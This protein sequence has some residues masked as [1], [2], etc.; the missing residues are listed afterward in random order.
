MIA[1]V[2]LVALALATVW[3][4]GLSTAQIGV[5]VAAFALQLVLLRFN[6]LCD[7]ATT[8]EV[9]SPA[10]PRLAIRRATTGAA[11]LA[12]VP[13]AAVIAPA[14]AAC[15]IVAV[16]LAYLRPLTALIRL[17]LGS[18]RLAA[19]AARH[20]AR[21]SYDIVFYVAGPDNAGYQINQ[22]LPV[23]ER[24]SLKA[25]I[26]IRRRGIYDGMRP[27][28]LAVIHARRAVDCERLLG[29]GVGVVLYPAN[30]IENAAA[31]RHFDL[32]HYFINH[33]ESDKR[34]NQSKF[35]M[36]YDKLL[37]AGPLAEARLTRAGLPLR[38]GQV[39]HVGRPQVEMLV[40]AATTPAPLRHILYAP[41]WEGYVDK[42][43]YSSVSGFGLAALRAILD[44]TDATIT[45]KP[46][47]YTGTRSKAHRRALAE[48]ESLA[49]THPRLTLLDRMA[50][51][52]DAMNGCDLLLADVG[53]V[54]NDFLASGKPVILCVTQGADAATFIAQNPT[55]AAAYL[56][57]QPDQAGALVRQI[58]TDDSLAGQRRDMRHQSLGQFPEGALARFESVLSA[59]LAE[60][61][62]AARGMNHATD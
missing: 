12:A 16:A 1:G 22:W 21:E 59:G 43:D 32:H 49:R 27:T 6:K 44:A 24:L 2:T 19:E 30:P 11:L 37:V 56:L 14:A 53:S 5:T 20:I 35:L 36:A 18:D 58:G 28:P 52:Y 23:A 48:L 47:P 55:A 13:A 62:A 45:V 31:L 17:R 60:A 15:T 40:N 4:G 42:M 9:I 8:L 29:S 46:H 7:R 26:C 39:V 34:V 50:P 25:A 41:T 3:N 61:R 10:A 51:I 57:H 54:V 33:G 38:A